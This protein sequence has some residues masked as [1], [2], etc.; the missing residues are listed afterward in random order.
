MPRD[1][2]RN[3]CYV[4]YTRI[5]DC[6]SQLVIQ[7]RLT[8]HGPNTSV[9]RHQHVGQKQRR[10]EIVGAVAIL[11]ADV[12]PA[13]DIPFLRNHKMKYASR[14]LGLSLG[15]GAAARDASSPGAHG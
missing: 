10:L 12:L 9:Y 1:L 11:L 8:L 15:Y 5:T 4:G 3:I 7:T 13:R 6:Q 14:L 2:I